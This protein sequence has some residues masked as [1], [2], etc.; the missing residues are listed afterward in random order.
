MEIVLA[1]AIIAAG[2]V[3]I[4]QLVRR[5]WPKEKPASP[6]PIDI[7]ESAR[8]A[9]DRH[10]HPIWVTDQTGSIIWQNQSAH[11]LPADFIYGHIC[12]ETSPLLDK[13][14][15]TGGE[16]KISQKNF[17]PHTIYFAEP[18]R[19]KPENQNDIIKTLSSTFSGLPIGLAIFDKDQNLQTFNPS[20]VATTCVQIDYLLQKPSLGCFIDNLRHNGFLFE[21]KNYKTW[22]NSI[23]QAAKSPVGDTF[24]Q[25]WTDAH[26]KTFRMSVKPDAAGGAIMLIEDITQPTQQTRAYAQMRDTAFAALEAMEN[27][28]ILFDKDGDIL[29]CNSK[30]RSVWGHDPFSS[31]AP[32]SIQDCERIWCIKTDMG[33]D[34]LQGFMN[35]AEH[36]TACT[37]SMKSNSTLHMTAKRTENRGVLIEFAQT[38]QAAEEHFR[39]QA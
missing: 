10:P 37:L 9:S 31:Q 28:V 16:Y 21:P 12:A 36:K 2:Q 25:T 13:H 38:N 5:Y 27:A 4:W 24:S 35:N 17:G 33:R 32:L 29:F 15:D 19:A 23:L 22:R 14:G 8:A 6:L 34:V 39:L 7:R 26:D 30:Y 20:L 18:H 1:S 11:D 3:L